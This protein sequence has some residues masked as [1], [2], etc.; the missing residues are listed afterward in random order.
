MKTWKDI[1]GW[2]DFADLYDH[3]VS[4]TNPPAVFVELGVHHGQSLIYLGQAVKNSGKDIKIYGIGIFGEIQPDTPKITEVNQ[5]LLDCGVADSVNLI[6]NYSDLAAVGFDS[7]SVD[8]IFIDANYRYNAVVRDILAWRP[9]IKPGGIMAGHD[10]PR[11][12]VARAVVA[13]LGKYKPISKS[14]WMVQM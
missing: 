3:M 7:K 11:I 13:T 5:N 9:K 6:Q 4:I 14:S 12:D 1:E 8:F 10:R 2:F